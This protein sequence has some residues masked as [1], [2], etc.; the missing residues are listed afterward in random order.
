MCLHFTTRFLKKKG[1][2][3]CAFVHKCIDTDAKQ[4]LNP[5]IIVFKFELPFKL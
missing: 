3:E 4:V 2:K 5:A 1:K